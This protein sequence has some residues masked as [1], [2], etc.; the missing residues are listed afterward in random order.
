MLNVVFFMG[1]IDEIDSADSNIRYVLVTGEFKNIKGVIQEDLVP[2]V[3]W[4]KTNKGQLFT[5]SKGSLVLIKGRL[6]IINRK[7]VVVC[8]NLSYLG[9]K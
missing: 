8:E 9:K 5:L 1:Q 2:V 7:C 6:E 3:S 4:T